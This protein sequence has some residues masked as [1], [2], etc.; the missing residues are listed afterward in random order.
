MIVGCGSLKDK[1]LE[2]E[3][4]KRFEV[5]DFDIYVDMFERDS[6]DYGK[7]IVVDDLI[8]NFVDIEQTRDDRFTLG[9]CI[10]KTGDNP[11]IVIDSDYWELLSDTSRVLLMYHEMGHCIL[12]R[13]HRDSV[14]SIMNSTLISS[15]KF[16][17]NKGELLTEL[18]QYMRPMS[19]YDHDHEFICDGDN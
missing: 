2:P 10:I 1:I 9:R 3:Y 13:S 14:D 4:K 12:R 5:G 19:L 7:G 11:L 6:V 16:E 17:Q 15:Y 8:I 18:F